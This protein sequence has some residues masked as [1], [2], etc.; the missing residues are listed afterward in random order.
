MTMRECARLQSM[1]DLAYLPESQTAAHK[2]LGNAVNVDV[3][4]AVATALLTVPPT[5][6]T[7]RW[8]TTISVENSHAA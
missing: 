8:D 5:R 7:S 1:G 2:A 3:I 6:D 4:A